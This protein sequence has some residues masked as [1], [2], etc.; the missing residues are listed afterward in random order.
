MKRSRWTWIGI[1][2]GAGYI[3]GARAGH[4]RYQQ[5][6]D[7][8]HR[9]SRN[10]GLPSAV[11]RVTGAS[12]EAAASTVVAASS[13]VADTL[14]DLSDDLS[15]RSTFKEALTGTIVTA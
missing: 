2:A 11:A 6:A 1:G 4:E 15:S 14:T 7:W 8:G 3:L 13:A 9:A 5:L 12:K 10:V